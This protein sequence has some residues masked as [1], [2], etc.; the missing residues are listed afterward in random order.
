MRTSSFSSLYSFSLASPSKGRYLQMSDKVSFH[1]RIHAIFSM[2]MPYYLI[3]TGFSLLSI[4]RAPY[5]WFTRLLCLHY[6]STSSNKLTFGGF[7]SYMSSPSF[8]LLKAELLQ[9]K[10]IGIKRTI[11]SEAIHGAYCLLIFSSPNP[12]TCHPSNLRSLNSILSPLLLAFYF[13]LYSFVGDFYWSPWALP[14][15]IHHKN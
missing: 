8:T 15:I 14:N 1:N 7:C 9:H 5:L 13:L 3:P 11:T 4:I 12:K 2:T 10:S 6:H